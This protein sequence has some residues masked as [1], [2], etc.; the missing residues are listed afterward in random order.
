MLWNAWNWFWNLIT[1]VQSLA[2]GIGAAFLVLGLAWGK[3]GLKKLNKRRE[4]QVYLV[5][6]WSAIV[7]LGILAFV[8]TVEFITYLWRLLPGH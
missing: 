5:A 8:V 3:N 6:G 2:F 4:G 1:T 7:Y